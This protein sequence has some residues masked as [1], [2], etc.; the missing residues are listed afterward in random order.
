MDEQLLGRIR[1]D[2]LQRRGILAG[3]VGH[4][5]EEIRS[6][7]SSHMPSE[8]ADA[9]QDA[10]VHDMSVS[11]MA[12]EEDEIYRID[13]AL[14]KIEAGEYG[15]CEECDEPINPERIEALPHARFCIACQRAFERQQ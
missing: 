5:A 7:A 13:E 2:L 1:E 9:G 6:G 11:R 8:L 4:L 12:S 15:D 10:A 3:D 14:R